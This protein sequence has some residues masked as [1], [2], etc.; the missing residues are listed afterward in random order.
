MLDIDGGLVASFSATAEVT[1]LL[2][3]VV[4]FREGKLRMRHGQLDS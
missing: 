2:L 3:L 1:V 4:S